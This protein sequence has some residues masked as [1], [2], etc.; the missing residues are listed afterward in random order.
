MLST[1]RRATDQVQ[2]TRHTKL[3]GQHMKLHIPQLTIIHD[4]NHGMVW[5]DCLTGEQLHS[6]CPGRLAKWW[7]TI[8]YD[9][10]D[11]SRVN[12]FILFQLYRRANPDA[13]ACKRSYDQQHS[14][15][16]LSCSWQRLLQKL[17]FLW[18]AMDCSQLQLRW[19]WLFTISRGQPIQ[20]NVLLCYQQDHVQCKCGFRHH[21]WHS[22]AWYSNKLLSGLSNTAVIQ[23]KLPSECF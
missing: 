5:V 21:M 18:Q 6:L 14:A 8:F 13:V 7:K 2:I 1:Y 9:F 17:L 15:L 11:M 22:P 19:W 10:V 4:N 20:E 16:S 3:N 12:G 23:E